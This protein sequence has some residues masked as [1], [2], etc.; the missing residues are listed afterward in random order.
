M[1]IPM[2]VTAAFLATVNNASGVREHRPSRSRYFPHLLRPVFTSSISLSL[3]SGNRSRPQPL[4]HL[5]PGCSHHHNY[6]SSLPQFGDRRTKHPTSPASAFTGAPPS[7][8]R[9]KTLY[10]SPPPV[11]KK[12]PTKGKKAASP[13][14]APGPAP[15]S[16]PAP[17]PPPA[18]SASQIS[19]RSYAQAAASFPRF[20]LSRI[21]VVMSFQVPACRG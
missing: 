20:S 5:K 1:N 14:T 18:S 4:S 7:A 15:S 19:P 17:P 8:K 11:P 9:L 6:S 12:L 2:R 3:S 10:P 13:A 21:I 16:P